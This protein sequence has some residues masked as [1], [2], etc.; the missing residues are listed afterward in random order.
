MSAANREVF[1]GTRDWQPGTSI[2]G[3]GRLQINL[4]PVALDDASPDLRRRLALLVLLIRVVELLQAGRALRTMRI[5]KAAMQ[6][7]VP[8]AVA[9][10]VARL[11]MQHIRNL[12]RE[13]ISVGLKS[14]LRVRAPQIGFG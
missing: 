6:A 13:L 5:L 14:V 4:L 10:A 7:I 2:H 3:R 8:H 9:I 11:L 12:R 1:L